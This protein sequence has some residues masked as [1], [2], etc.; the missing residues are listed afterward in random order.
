MPA[1]G[2]MAERALGLD[3][4]VGQT[5]GAWGLLLKPCSPVARVS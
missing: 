2:L 5:I 3:E 4:R 1:P